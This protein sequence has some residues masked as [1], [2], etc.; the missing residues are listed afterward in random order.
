MKRVGGL[1][2]QVVDFE[3]LR[4]AARRASRGT[5][6][7]E[8]VAFLADLELNVL[9]LQAQ[10]VDG[11]WQP[12]TPHTFRILDPKPRTITSVPFADRVV[13]HA[14]CAAL[15]PVLESY[16]V[17]HSYACR[18]GKGNRSAV[19]AAQH[20]AGRHP[21]FVKLDVRHFFET[22]YHDR[23]LA[24]LGRRLK[25][26]AVLDLV[27]RILAGGGTLGRGLPI[28][29]LTSQQLGNFLLGRVDHYATEGLRVSGWVRYMDDMLAFGA[30]RA[31]VVQAAAGIER[32]VREDLGQEL[33]H[34]ATRIDRTTSGV[35][36][37]G[38]RV[39]PRAIRLDAARARRFVK[40]ARTL[41]CG[42]WASP[43][44]RAQSARGLF[45]WVGQARTRGLRARALA[46]FEADS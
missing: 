35:P 42:A 2:P 22:V 46:A 39:W 27:R 28:G 3:A 5:R 24:T 20:F 8:S 12:G 41:R 30:T 21:W 45:D 31:S 4:T 43:E 32:F 7:R 29:S 38:F 18:K 11:S 40:R 6:T 17:H 9:R 33:K 14:V 19:A 10:L 1:F 25:D 15:E 16:A 36:W 44:L 37:L 26:A 34:E 13:H 23:L